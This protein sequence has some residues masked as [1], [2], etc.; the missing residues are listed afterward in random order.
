MNYENTNVRTA[1]EEIV[2]LMKLKAN[3]RHIQLF[4]EIH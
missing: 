4:Y 2:S 1:I 3:L